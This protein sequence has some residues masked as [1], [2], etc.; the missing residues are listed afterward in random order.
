MLQKKEFLDSPKGTPTRKL[1]LAEVMLK[2]NLVSFRYHKY[3]EML[4]N[5]MNIHHKTIAF[6]VDYELSKQPA[7]IVSLFIREV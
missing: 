2:N 4:S 5:I 1:S 7:T 6:I 3:I